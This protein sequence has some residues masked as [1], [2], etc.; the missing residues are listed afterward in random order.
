MNQAA[1]RPSSRRRKGVAGEKRRERIFQIVIGWFRFRSS[2]DQLVI[3]SAAIKDG[4]VFDA[5]RDH[6]GRPFHA[7]AIR[8]ELSFVLENWTVDSQFAHFSAN[9]RHIILRI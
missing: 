5:D 7:E 3:E 1:C 8:D 2:F 6:F 9:S 4:P